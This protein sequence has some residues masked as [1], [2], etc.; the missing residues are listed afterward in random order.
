MKRKQAEFLLT[1][2]GVAEV[3]ATFYTI[4]PPMAMSTTG[5]AAALTP[6]AIYCLVIYLY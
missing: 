3:V 2:L 1:V 6:V 5:V 4:Y